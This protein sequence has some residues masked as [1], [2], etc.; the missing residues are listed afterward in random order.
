VAEIG[1]ELV[2]RWLPRP[3]G[4]RSRMH[5]RSFVQAAR[6]WTARMLQ[7]RVKSINHPSLQL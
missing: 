2:Q 5:R 4:A 7:C 3:R 6:L 1:A